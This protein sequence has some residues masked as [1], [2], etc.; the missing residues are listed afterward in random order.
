[1]TLTR[2]L[3]ETATKTR[4]TCSD[5]FTYFLI[6]LAPLFPVILAHEI[7]L[8]SSNLLLV[9]FLKFMW[10]YGWSFMFIFWSK[11]YDNSFEH[12]NILEQLMPNT[13][14]LK[15][16]LTLFVSISLLN[17]LGATASSL[18]HMDLFKNHYI[19]F[20]SKVGV[21]MLVSMLL[22]YCLT[23]SIFVIIARFHDKKLSIA[24][25][26]TL[27]KNITPEIL[28]VA[29][30]A[31]IPYITFVFIY[32]ATVIR[33]MGAYKAPYINE[34][35]EILLKILSMPIDAIFIPWIAIIMFTSALHY[36]KNT[37]L[38]YGSK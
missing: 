25:S 11:G 8:P 19:W 13:K 33:L 35:N 29:T 23:R 16:T 20:Y 6:C 4:N 18:I 14:I 28:G 7:F 10:L 34:T 36:Y 5:A 37:A 12:N 24:Q 31:A 22:I 26:F 9:L 2:T 27:T 21:S 30:I 38:Q 15:T 1:M 3:I 17:Y 32:K